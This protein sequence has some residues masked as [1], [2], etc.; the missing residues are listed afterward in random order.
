[1]SQLF[2][3]FGDELIKIEAVE[4]YSKISG[5]VLYN[6]LEDI[7][8]VV[9]DALKVVFLNKQEIFFDPSF[10]VINVGG[11]EVEKL[12]RDHKKNTMS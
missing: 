6:M 10:L 7:E 8:G 12:W 11:L 3:E 5:I 1:M 4:Q 9:C 2:L